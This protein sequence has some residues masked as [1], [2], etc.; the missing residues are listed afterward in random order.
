M[1]TPTKTTRNTARTERRLVDSIRKA[2]SDTGQPGDAEPASTQASGAATAS[3]PA[4]RAKA[5]GAGAAARPVAPKP[6]ASAAAA[7]SS[8][9]GYQSRRRVWPD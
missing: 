7:E 5:T 6:A 8:V 4:R 3:A 9:G 2:K 1:T